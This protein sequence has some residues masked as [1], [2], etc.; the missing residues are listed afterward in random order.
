MPNLTTSSMSNS[1]RTQYVADYVSGAVINRIYDQLAFPVSSD[2]ANIKRG[3]SVSVPFISSLDPSTQ[4]ISETSDMTPAPMRDATVTVT[5]TSRGNAILVSE[6]LLN[7]NYTNFNGTYY[8]KLGENMMTSIDI[9]AMAAAVSGGFSRSIAARSSLDA[10]TSTHRL[11]K[12]SFVNAS[13]MMSAMKVP[14]S[15]TPRGRRWVSIMHPFTF[16]DLMQDAVILAVGEYQDAS[17]ILNYELGEINGFSLVVTPWAKVFW[18]AASANASP[19]NT[20]ITADANA[21]STSVT[22]A[23]ATNI[24]VGNRIWIGPAVETGST[25]YSTNESVIVKSVVS[26]TIGVI[27]EG[28]NGG[29]RYN[30]AASEL[31]KNTDGAYPV[32][33]GG[34]ESIAKVYDTEVGEY[35]AIVGPKKDGLADQFTTLAWKWYG[36]YGLI[37]E[38]RI[39]RTEVSSSMEA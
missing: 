13:V 28:E 2:M 37:S 31:C 36:A 29:L 33:F 25:Y 14:D 18:G 27:G 20:T 30:H 38:S 39:L 9:M 21:L 19:V 15:L 17:M 8:K 3:S 12:Q 6:A 22:V 32:V 24:T 7:K 11:T 23:S 35:G 4:A 10:G 34:P 1:V 26:T 5:P 16:Q